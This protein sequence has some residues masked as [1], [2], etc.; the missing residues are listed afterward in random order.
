MERENFLRRK[1]SIK[2]PELIEL[3]TKRFWKTEKN[4][5]TKPGIVFRGPFLE[6]PGNLPNPDKVTGTFE[7]RAPGSKLYVQA[8]AFD[9]LTESLSSG[10]VVS[11]P[12]GNRKHF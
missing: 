2:E 8:Q 12:R 6:S 3:L 7:K 1:N 10:V 4:I 9:S 11:I 5:S